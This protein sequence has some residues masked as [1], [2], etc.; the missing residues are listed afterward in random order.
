MFNKF[1]ILQIKTLSVIVLS[2]ILIII[3]SKFNTFITVKNCSDSAISSLYFSIS[4]LFK[5]S[6][7]LLLF[8]KEHKQ[9]ILENN[10]LRTNLLLKNS[11]LL[12]M[13]MYKKENQQLYQLLSSP[14]YH[15]QIRKMITKIIAVN[16]D[17]HRHQIIIDKGTNNNVYIGQ[18]VINDKGVIGQVISTNKFT[19]R[20]MLICDTAHALPTQI[21]RNNVRLI[22]TG[23]GYNKD[24]QLEYQ[25]SDCIDVKIGDI[26]ITS[27]LGGNFPKGYPVAVVSSITIDKHYKCTKIQA[28]PITKLQYLSNLLLIW[29]NENDNKKLISNKY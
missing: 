17:P 7:N 12:L 9:L 6:K 10:I 11:D 28:R 8:L 24:L 1:N 15:H 25:Q 2:V 13:E 22:A 23:N 3:D 26:L 16:I 27:G 29:N 14:P 5:I 4:N 19:S 18:P 20:V 21:I